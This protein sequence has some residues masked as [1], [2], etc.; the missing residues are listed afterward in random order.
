VNQSGN[1]G[2]GNDLA[3]KRTGN[4]KKRF[5]FQEPR[6]FKDEEPSEH[7]NGR[8]GVNIDNNTFRPG[9]R[10]GKSTARI[11]PSVERTLRL[12]QGGHEKLPDAKKGEGQSTRL[13][14]RSPPLGRLQDKPRAAQGRRHLLRQRSTGGNT[15]TDRVSFVNFKALAIDDPQK[16]TFKS[17]WEARLFTL[18]LLSSERKKLA[19]KTPSGHD[20]NWKQRV[21]GLHCLAHGKNE[22]KKG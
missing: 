15:T 4:L 13:G 5:E 18:Q 12:S 11:S 16:K 21:T 14:K 8:E 19:E 2:E 22:Q 6:E 17:R 9:I 7:S 20:Q 1:H 3:V 10:K